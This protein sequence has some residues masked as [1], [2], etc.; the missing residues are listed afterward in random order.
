MPTWVMVS[1]CKVALAEPNQ[2]G[3]MRKAPTEWTTSGMLVGLP[4]ETTSAP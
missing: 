4:D 1:L 3:A 2:M